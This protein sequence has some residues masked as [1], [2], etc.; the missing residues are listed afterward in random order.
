[1]IMSRP[2]KE[3]PKF[4]AV[5]VR[6]ESAEQREEWKAIAKSAGMTVSG[7]ISNAF[8]SYKS[9]R[10]IPTQQEEVKLKILVELQRIRAQGG[11]PV[12]L[13]QIADYVCKN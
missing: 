12:H 8:S 10:K 6:V 1:M 5:Q 4:L 7:F 2:R 3:N 11:D 9:K 13:K